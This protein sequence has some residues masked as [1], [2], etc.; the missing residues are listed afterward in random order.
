MENTNNNVDSNQ[1]PSNKELYDQKKKEKD[2][3]KQKLGSQKK[4]K[5]TGKYFLYLIILGAILFGLYGLTKDVKRLPPTSMQNHIEESPPSHIMDIPIPENI[6]K[7]MLEHADGNGPSGIIIQYNCDD[8]E[9]EEGLVDKLT[10]LVKEYPANV[11]LAPNTYDGKI[12][13]TKLGKRL[14]LKAFD[15]KAIREFIG[16]NREISDEQGSVLDDTNNVISM[17]SAVFSFTPNTLEASVGEAV[18]IEISS[19]GQHTFTIDELGV[20]VTTPNGQITT[21]EFTPDKTGTFQF[22]CATPGHREAGQIGT[23]T[24]K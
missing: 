6:Q 13:L 7:H 3:E 20:D 11:Y 1:Q 21:V 23:I 15:E 12:I 24:V 9:C 14:V 10:E 19:D 2:A 17:E 8:Y 4:A 18:K 22:Y 16:D 5:S